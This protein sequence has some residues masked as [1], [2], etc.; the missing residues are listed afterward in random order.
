MKISQAASLLGCS[1]RRI[2]R[3]NQRAKPPKITRPTMSRVN[4]E[5]ALSHQEFG[6]FCC[7]QGAQRRAPHASTTSITRHTGSRNRPARAM[8]CV[9]P[10]HWPR[11]TTHD[12]RPNHQAARQ[13]AQKQKIRE[14]NAPGPLPVAPDRHGNP[15]QHRRARQSQQESEGRERT[16]VGPMW[17]GRGRVF[18]ICP[19]LPVRTLL[20]FIMIG[21][22]TFVPG[23]WTPGVDARRRTGRPARRR[24]VRTG[25]G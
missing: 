14:Q 25:P 24:T 12:G 16:H 5:G 4:R 10:I 2:A 19:I 9:E 1:P 6:T 17:K 3:T 8:F 11:E 15:A 13:A 7:S 23:A 18:P 20:T 21:R 22:H